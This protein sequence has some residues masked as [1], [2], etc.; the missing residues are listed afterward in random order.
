MEGDDLGCAGAKSAKRMAR[1]KKRKLPDLSGP[2]VQDFAESS[3]PL[4][5]EKGH[6]AP[7]EDASIE[8]PLL[9]A[10]EDA[11]V[12]IEPRNNQAVDE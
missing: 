2:A 4:G 5:L 8:G 12:D 9:D 1:A 11:C 10:R 7:A 3:A 6:A